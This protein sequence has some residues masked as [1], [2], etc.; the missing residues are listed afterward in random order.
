VFPFHA[1]AP[2]A[3]SA[4]RL[5][6]LALMASVVKAV[7]VLA[8]VRIAGNH[9]LQPSAVAVIT[10]LAI[11]SIGFGNL[12]ALRQS[13][14]KRLLAYSSVAHAG[15]MIFALTDLTGSRAHDLLWYTL[16]YGLASVLAC[17]SFAVLCP[18]DDDRLERLDGQFAQ[19][20]VASVVLALAVLSLAGVPPLPGFFAKVF[21]FKSVI[22]SGHAMAATIAFIGSFLGLAYYVGIAL[23]PFRPAAAPGT[24]QSTGETR[25]RDRMVA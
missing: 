4:A 15:Y 13:R 3:Y 6:A 5:P 18:G 8:L 16:F 14:F 7:V 11:V 20:P 23:R 10:V 19:R 21:V 9:P 1:W 22:A 17:A 24:S 2:D 25:Q 12:T